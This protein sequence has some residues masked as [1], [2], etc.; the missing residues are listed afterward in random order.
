MCAER[1]LGTLYRKIRSVSKELRTVVLNNVQELPDGNEH[2]DPSSQ[3]TER[4]PE[5]RN[6]GRCELGTIY[7]LNLSVRL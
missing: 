7:F 3:M 1:L 4:R 2:E 5:Y 6:L